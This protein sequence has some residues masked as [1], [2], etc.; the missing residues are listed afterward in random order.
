MHVYIWLLVLILVR[1]VV[2]SI[3]V[4]F[5]YMGCIST[6][7]ASVSDQIEVDIDSLAPDL[8]VE[9]CSTY[10][11]EN[12]FKDFAMNIPIDGD[13]KGLLVC[14]CYQREIMTDLSRF[15]PDSCNVY[16]PRIYSDMKNYVCG[17][18]EYF[19][20]WYRL[21]EEDDMFPEEDTTAENLLSSSTRVRKNF[22]FMS[23]ISLLAFLKYFELL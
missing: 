23:I 2:E 10:C 13:F 6:A 8:A 16:C 1:N 3:D 5:D 17:S 11:L 14:T 18:G 22:R 20:S 12:L 9:Y 19:T 15:Y 4:T 7:D 21:R